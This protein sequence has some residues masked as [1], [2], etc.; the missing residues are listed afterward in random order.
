MRLARRRDV[1]AVGCSRGRRA[2]WPE[3][4]ALW[5]ALCVW[6]TGNPSRPRRN[7]GRNLRPISARSRANLAPRRRSRRA[8]GRRG[9]SGKRMAGTCR[10]GSRTRLSDRSGGRAQPRAARGMPSVQAR[11]T[12]EMCRLMGAR[13][14]MTTQNWSRESGRPQE[15]VTRADAG[16]RKRPSTLPCELSSDPYV[17]MTK[18]IGGRG[19][20]P[21]RPAR[22]AAAAPNRRRSTA[23]RA[24]RC[25][26]PQPRSP[27]APLCARAGRAGWR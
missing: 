1:R 14:R 16:R 13:S 26:P 17:I 5:P 20:A 24:A 22:T 21:C 19:R 15:H 11:G 18:N 25:R 3:S 23:C 2:P 4:L 8:A 6:T 12:P 10:A 7:T 27:A 9:G